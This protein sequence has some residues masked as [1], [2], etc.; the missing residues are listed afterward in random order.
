MKIAGDSGFL[1]FG[2]Q[3][4]AAQGCYAVVEGVSEEHRSSGIWISTAA[5]STAGIR[6]AGGKVM[7]TKSQRL[8]YLVRELYREPQR[9]YALTRGFIEPDQDFVVVSKMQQAHLYIDGA[10][11]AYPFPFG[12][13]ARFKLAEHHLRLFI[14]APALQRQ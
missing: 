4:N 10:R 14:G 11:T 6:S 2:E 3:D 1:Q 12:A 5:G 7:P 13:H 8:Q 9:N